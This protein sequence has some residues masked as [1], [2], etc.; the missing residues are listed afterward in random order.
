MAYVSSI[1]QHFGKGRGKKYSHFSSQSELRRKY[2]SRCWLKIQGSSRLVA[3]PVT[4]S[5]NVS[6]MGTGRCGSDGHLSVQESASLLCLESSGSRGVGDRCPGTGCE[7]G[8]I[9]PSIHFP[10]IPLDRAGIEEGRGA[11][12]REGANGG[13][14]VAHQTIL[15]HTVVHDSG[16]QAV[17]AQQVAGHRHGDRAVSPGRQA[18]PLG[19]I[20][21]FWESRHEV[22][23]LSKEAQELVGASWRGSTEQ[24]YSSAW[25][26]WCQY[27][28]EFG[29]SPTSP[30][31]NNI[32][33]YL[34]H[35]FKLGYKYRSI[36][37]HRSALS[38]TLKPI[39]S[40]QVGQHPLVKR[41]M[42]GVFNTRPPVQKLCESWSVMKVLQLLKT[43]SPA[44]TLDLKCL[45]LKTAML[46]ALATAKRCS[47]LS[48]LTLKEGFCEISESMVRLQPAGL[49]K[50][51]RPDM[52]GDPIVLRSYN[53]EPRLDPVNYLKIYI[54][55]TKL[56]RKSENLFVITV[57]PHG[58]ATKQ[59]ISGWL[60]QVIRMSGQTGTGGSVRPASTSYAV[61][62]GA[63]LETVLQAG[64]WARASTFRRFYYKAV[65]L[66]FHNL[67]LNQ[68]LN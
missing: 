17:E 59:T 14:L 7:L 20:H 2:H 45:T 43:W 19:R 51:N 65:P 48:L 38:S 57:A 31:L 61:A 29:F 9:L 28:S 12:G 33:E 26:K 11:E 63:S 49:E 21:D 42:R 41:L 27:C 39:Q 1:S 46:L 4:G 3:G 52:M 23:G 13:T 6:Q 53:E 35:L 67:V 15:H 24:H 44:R 54:K 62:R 36:N 66:K 5:E 37:V 47:S 8:C 18:L 56:I 55:R 40:Y 60:A 34:A 32:L 58:A 25:R 22:Y 68:E 64:D 50:H 30:S 16:G 10:P